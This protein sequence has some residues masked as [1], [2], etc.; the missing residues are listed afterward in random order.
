M[1]APNDV[2]PTMS[3]PN[4]VKPAPADD[5]KTGKSYP[6]TGLCNYRESD[7]SIPDNIS[8]LLIGDEVILGDYA[9]DADVS[10]GLTCRWSAFT[11]RGREIRWRELPVVRVVARPNDHV[12]L[13]DYRAGTSTPTYVGVY[14]GLDPVV[15]VVSDAW[16]DDL[17]NA[18]AL[19]GH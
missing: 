5:V 13:V 18:R 1:S 12:L 10:D 8:Q 11:S 7:G 4:D 6:L 2:K 9:D 15:S 14:R 16:Y 19:R 3:A 17:V